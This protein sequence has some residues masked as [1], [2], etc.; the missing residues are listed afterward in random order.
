M[1]LRCVWILVLSALLLALLGVSCARQP[2]HPPDMAPRPAAREAEKDVESA[3]SEEELEAI[4]EPVSSETQPADEEEE[5]SSYIEQEEP[6]GVEETEIESGYRV[7]IFAS[8]SL[9]RAEEV[10]SEARA[11]FTERV[12]VEYSVPLYKVRVG[13]FLYKEEALQFR[14]RAIE[15]GYEGAWV[16]EAIIEPE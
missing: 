5:I 4:P 11:V 9:E 8:S 14:Q 7:Q 13:D 1:L 16:A 6:A 2:Y 10:A 12:Y 3:A 15:A